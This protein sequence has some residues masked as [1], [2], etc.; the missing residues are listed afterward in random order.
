M[1]IEELVTSGELSRD[2]DGTLKAHDLRRE[3]LDSVRHWVASADDTQPQKVSVG[4][5]ISELG[6]VWEDVSSEWFMGFLHAVCE[7]E[8]GLSPDGTIFRR[9]QEPFY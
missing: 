1:A 3:A 2:E 8:V 6:C 9:E 5:V 4:E 7:G